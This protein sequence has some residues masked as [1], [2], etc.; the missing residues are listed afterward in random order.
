[1]A[2]TYSDNS[3]T[4]MDTLTLG[5]QYCSIDFKLP[6]PYTD[7]M[8][9]FWSRTWKK[10]LLNFKIVNEFEKICT[11][12]TMV[13]IIVGVNHH[14]KIYDRVR[15]LWLKSLTE[16]GMSAFHFA[17]TPPSDLSIGGGL[18]EGIVLI[19][20]V[21]FGYFGLAFTLSVAE[22]VRHIFVFVN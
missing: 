11:C 15:L 4:R 12:I 21:R 2:L 1:M 8:K 7:D 16:K 3:S 6:L 13:H 14:I 19:F 22:K 17:T 9:F 5:K 18:K 10:S 20:K